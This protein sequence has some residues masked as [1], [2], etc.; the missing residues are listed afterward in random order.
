M[1][2]AT[3]T[4]HPRRMNVIVEQPETPS[5]KCKTCMKGTAKMICAVI[6][7]PI[8]C[9]LS[10]LA[11][12]GYGI[13]QTAQCDGGG[14]CYKDEMMKRNTICMGCGILTSMHASSLLCIE[15]ANDI[16]KSITVQQNMSR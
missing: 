16:K 3:M 11:G 9:P 12:T 10:C 14:P 1:I 7:C 5:E 2:D 4:F 6:A 8:I 15:G 13:Y